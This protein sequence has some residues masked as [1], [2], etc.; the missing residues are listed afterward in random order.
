MRKKKKIWR[1]VAVRLYSVVGE[2]LE[3][4][5][6]YVLRKERAARAKLETSA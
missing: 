1:E 6:S 2:V 5:T 4:Q 3:V